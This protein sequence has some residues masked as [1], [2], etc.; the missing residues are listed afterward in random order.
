MAANGTAWA[1]CRSRPYALFRSGLNRPRTCCAFAAQVLQG[2]EEFHIVFAS[3]RQ[4]QGELSDERYRYLQACNWRLPD[5]MQRNAGREMM[6]GA[7]C[8]EEAIKRGQYRLRKQAA[9]L[10]FQLVPYRTGD[11]PWESAYKL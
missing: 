7:G 5:R 9:P 8:D 6:V 1:D 11:V 3:S 10:G 4:L 2:R